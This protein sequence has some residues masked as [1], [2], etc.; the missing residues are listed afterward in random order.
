MEA[1]ISGNPRGFYEYKEIEWLD[2]PKQINAVE[3]QDLDHIQQII[4]TLGE[5]RID[6]D[7]DNLRLWA[8]V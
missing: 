5:F 3:T 6:I 1:M 4:N 7:Q 2:F 8:Y